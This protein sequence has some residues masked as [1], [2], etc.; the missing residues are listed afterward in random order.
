MLIINDLAKRDIMFQA[1]FG[2]TYAILFGIEIRIR[3]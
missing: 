1:E 3:W 2:R